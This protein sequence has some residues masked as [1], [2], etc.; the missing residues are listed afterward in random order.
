MEPMKRSSLSLKTAPVAPTL[1]E[2]SGGQPVKIN[3]PPIVTYRFGR[4]FRTVATA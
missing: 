4:Y 3:P 1:S 2:W